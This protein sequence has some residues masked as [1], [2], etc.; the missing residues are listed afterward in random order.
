MIASDTKRPRNVDWKSAAAILYGDWGTSKAYVVGLAFAVA[1]YSSFWLIA[2]MCVLTA[3]VGVNYM[4]ICKHYPDGGGVYAS[5]RHRSEIISIVGA[6]LLIADYIVTA[7][8]SALSAFQY[9]QRVIP[10]PAALL[11]YCAAGAIVVIGVLNYLGP[12]HTG[13]LAFLV[14]VPTAVVVALLGFFCLPHVGAA[15]HHIKPLEGGFGANWSHFVGIVL[16]L[17]GVEAIANATGVMPLNP[18]CDPSKPCVSKTSTKALVVVMIEVCVFTALLGFGMQALHGL[19]VI[20][21]PGQDPDV[22]APD[23]HGVRDYMLNYM[24]QTFVTGSWGATA[25]A[26]AGAVVSIVFAVLLLSAVN[27]AIVDLIAIS[28]LMARDKELPGLFSKLNNYGVPNAGLIVATVIPAILV[29]VVSDMAGLANLYAVG[30][31]GAI[32]TNLGASSTDKKLDLVRWERVLMFCTFLIMLAIEISL[33][34]EKPDARYFAGSVLLIGL[35]MRGLASEHL[36]RKEKAAATASGA[37]TSPE[38][39]IAIPKFQHDI[40]TAPGAPLLCAIRG[41]GRTMKFAIEEARETKRPL[42]LLFVRQQPA[43]TE[44]DRKRKWQDDPEALQ[45]FSEASELADG[46]TILPCYA[47]SDSPADTIVDIA[48]TVGASRVILGGAKRSGLISALRGNLIRQ[49]SQLL[50]EEIPL[51]VYS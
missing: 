20:P 35:I 43:L 40:N 29:A 23:A 37:V 7:A 3:L 47:V 39:A 41:I 9:L 22:N 27:T 17:S 25:G 6:F 2:A 44:R 42:Y 33:F 8:I 28:F 46:H 4:T 26:I 36:Q 38:K 51:L 14:S 48:A 24:A 30:V 19:Q 15:I 5:V 32:A 11:G 50:P 16:A 18:G 31:V 13:N 34:V 49:V 1:G 12:K 10:I 45:I 21:V